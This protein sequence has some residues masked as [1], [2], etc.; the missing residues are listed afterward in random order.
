MNPMLNPHHKPQERQWDGPIHLPKSICVLMNEES[1]E[2]LKQYN[3]EP[4]QKFMNRTVQEALCCLDEP[5]HTPGAEPEDQPLQINTD[6]DLE[7]HDSILD[8]FNS[9]APNDEQ[10][11]QALQTYQVL[12]SQTTRSAPNRSLVLRHMM[13]LYLI[14]ST[15]RLLMMSNWSKHSRPIRS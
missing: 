7:T 15:A 2:G 5:T 4:L 6:H 1:K 11:E 12:T 10:L 9:Q 14:S 3:L 13:I 8:L